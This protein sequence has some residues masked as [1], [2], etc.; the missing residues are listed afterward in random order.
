MKYHKWLYWTNFVLL[1][2]NSFSTA[3]VKLLQMDFEMELFR[4]AGLTDTFTVAFGVAQL[5][6]AIVLSIPKSRH[7][8][9]GIM[10]ATFLF[11]TGVL[12]KVG[13]I[14]FAIFSLL[15]IAMASWPLL[16][17]NAPE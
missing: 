2:L 16:R 6:G 8:G 1:T 14:P 13:M 10:A 7:I 11:A 4:N 12:F 9:A 3:M 15:F 5:I 17:P